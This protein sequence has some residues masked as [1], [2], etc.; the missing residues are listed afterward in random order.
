VNYIDITGESR[1]A[2]TDLSLIASDGLHYSGKEY[3]IWA[4]LL[5]QQI[6]KILR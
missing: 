2:A 5:A 6:E 3:T 4:T 1:K